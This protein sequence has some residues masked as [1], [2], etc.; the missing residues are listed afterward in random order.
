MAHVGGEPWFVAVL[1]VRRVGG[2]QVE[3][4]VDAVEIRRFD[5]VDAVVHPVALGVAGGDGQ[6]VA[7]DVGGRDPGRR[8]FVR[9]ADGDVAA[10]GADV[11]DLGRVE[12]EREAV[13]NLERFL[14]DELGF[15]PRDEHGGRHREIEAP[16]LPDADD[17]GGRLAGD[18]ARDPFRE[19]RLERGGSV[20][21]SFGEQPYAIPPE[22]RAREQRHV[23]GG[24]GR[25]DAG[26]HELRARRG[27]LVVQ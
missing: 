24:F 10:A 20:G 8:H 25:R 26:R 3:R 27:E 5:E 16:E 18:A 11:G 2:N 15:G 6:R 14:D 19:P 22:N 9:Q 4:V 13:Q 23:D 1:H 12:R 7:R 17:V 21:A